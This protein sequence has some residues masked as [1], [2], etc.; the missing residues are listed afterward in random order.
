MKEKGFQNAEVT[1]EIKEIP[2]GP[3]LVHLT[4]RIDEGPKIKLNAIEFV[5]N[6]AITDGKLRK[7][8]KNNKQRIIWARMFA[9]RSTYQE[10]KFDE[11]A[12]K[13]VEYYRDQGYITARVGAPEL[14]IVSDSDDK[15]TRLVDL[16]IPITEGNRYRVG[17][18][19][20]DG[21][22][23]VKSDDL[24][25]FFKVDQGKFYSEKAI[26]KGLEKT[27]EVY[28]AGGYFEFTG[29]PDYK[30]RDLPDPIRA[31]DAGR[32]QSRSP[33]AVRAADRRRHDEAGGRQAVLHQP[34][35]VHRQHDDAGQ[36][37]PAGGASVRGRRLQHGSAEVQHQAA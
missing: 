32:A 17:E 14:K 25:P 27:R 30:F 29:Y 10:A 19:G 9:G 13:V 20:F 6:Q 15:K 22:T 33:E 34:P 8:M 36:R 12:D 16:R 26:R 24:R 5:G 28:G 31:A 11:D 2:G 1:P 23:V 18:F 7:Q 4:Y 21:N 3:K 35:H 37:D